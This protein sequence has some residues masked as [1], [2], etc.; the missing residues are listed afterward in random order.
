LKLFAI[1]SDPADNI[2]MVNASTKSTST[3]P[4]SVHADRARSVLDAEARA[5][6]TVADHLDNAFDRAVD[7]V[8]HLQGSLIVSGIGKSGLVGQKLSATFSSTGQP[9]HFMHPTEA[10]HGDLGRLR[11]SDALLLL[12]YSGATEELTA[13]AA[14]VR[15]D[16]IPII[17]ITRSE[18]THLA[19]LSVAP[20]SVGEIEEAC[21]HNLAPT[22]STAAMLALGD[23]LAI[24]TSQARSFS[25]E[26]FK[27]AHPGGA[28]GRVMLPISSVLRF[29]APDTLVAMDQSVTVGQLIDQVPPTGVRRP[30]ATLL[31]GEDGVL[32]GLF[33]DADLRRLL[34][35]ERG[36]AFG[37]LLSEVMTKSPRSLH[38]SSLVRDAVQLVRELRIDEIPIVDDAGRPTGLLDVQDLMALKLID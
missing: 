29:K 31:V 36:D 10:M 26:D 19:Q 37:R 32:T 21:P 3:P 34:A 18:Q 23:A 24:A 13:L 17:S 5:I 25:A 20:L 38:S 4:P 35:R 9:S 16:E 8:T 2:R 27:R 15:Q 1:A 14:V 30:G 7:I 11:P 12:S 22:A 6:A 33:T 28:L